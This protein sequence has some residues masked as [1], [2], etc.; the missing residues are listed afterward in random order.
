MSANN[1]S[2]SERKQPPNA[3]S[4]ISEGGPLERERS[5]MDQ[6]LSVLRSREA[7]PSKTFPLPSSD[8]PSPESDVGERALPSNF[9]KKLLEEYRQRQQGG[10]APPAPGAPGDLLPEA[11]LPPPANNWIPIG[12]AVVRQGQASN[13]PAVSGRI[14]GLAIAPGG[15][16]IYAASA[17]GGVWRSDDGGLTWQ[18]TMEAWDLNPTTPSSDTLACGAIAINPTNPNRIFVGTGE[19]ASGAY[20][21]V[22]PIRSDN[23]GVSWVTEPTAPGSSTLEGS[24]FYRLAMDPGDPDRL[25][26]ATRQGLY[27][28]EPDG[29]GAFHWA[30]KSL[31]G[32]PYLWVTGVAAARSGSTTTFYAAS[33]GGSVYSSND[34]HTWSQ[35]GTGFPT[36]N[37]GRIGLAVQPNNPTVVYALICYWKSGD[38]NTGSMLGVWRLDTNDNI[39]RQVGGYPTDLF[40]TPG[41]YQG[42]YDLAIAV[43]P[44]N[45]N[46][47]YLGGST[48]SAGG[49]W[50]GSLYRCIVSSSGSG[51][52]LTY[53][54]ANTFIG[55]TVHADIHALEFT[56]G[57]SDQLWV[58]CD[59]GVF[60][61]DSATGSASFEARNVGLAC[62]TMNH[63][64]QHPTEDAVVFCGTQ[65]NGTT[66]FTGEEVWLHSAPGD[67]GFVV[68]NWNDPYRMLRTYVRGSIYRATDGGQSY[69][70]WSSV[71][72][73]ATHR[74]NALFYAPLVGTPH[75]TA[76]PAEA[77]I[78]AFGGQRPWLSTNFG[79]S[80]QSIPNNNSSDDLVGPI[81]SLAFA[82]AA[83]LY[84]GTNDSLLDWTPVNSAVYRFDKSGATWTRTRI[85]TVGGANVLPLDGPI[86]DIAIDLADPSGDSIYITFGGTGDYRHVWHFNGTQWQQRSGPAAGSAD[87]LLDVQYNAIVIDPSHTNH[88]YA[89]ADIGVWRSTDGGA[90]WS[91]FSNGLPDAAVLDLKLHN[92]RRLLRASTHGRGV[93]ERT[94]DTTMALGV[95]LYVRDTQLD[96]GRHPTTNGLD[97]PTQPGETVRHYQG[98]DIKVDVPSAMGTYQTPT[99]QINCYQF[100]DTIVDGSGG[101]ATVDPS[102]GTAINRMYVQVHN[103]GVT[104][105]SGVQVMVLLANAS[106]G[107]PNLPAGYDTDVRA[108]T[109]I[110][111]TN[112][113]TVGIQTLNDLQVGLPQIASFNL[114]SSMLPP[115]ASLAGNTH[116]CLLALLHCPGND[117]FTNTQTHVDTLSP[118]ERKAAHKNLHV[119]Q[120]TG[121]LPPAAPEWLAI[122]LH[123]I[124]EREV[125]SDLVLNLV[126]YQGRVRLMVPE[127][128][129]LTKSLD[130]SLVGLR[131]EDAIDFDEWAEKKL[132]QLDYYLEKRL[133]NA[134][135]C[136]QMIEAIN[137]V[138]G[139]PMLLAETTKEPAILRH[140]M[141]HP[142]EFHTIFVAINRPQEARIGD[143]YEF[144]IYQR[145]VERETMWGGSTYQV[146]IVP[147]PDVEEKLYL[148]I[149]G[150]R[151]WFRGYEVV[152][153]RVFD[154]DGAILGSGEGAEVGLFIH[155]N[156]G[157]EGK[158]RPMRYHRG[159]RAFWLRV[160]LLPHLRVGVVK[161][162]AVA[163]AQDREARKTETIRF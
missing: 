91:T 153:V 159:W 108:G 65:D 13:R 26:G 46:R 120:F 39:W 87:S 84:A 1:Q 144:T 47:V 139:Q 146:Q 40:G 152:F 14:A 34:G 22:G 60:Y 162:T 147:E 96:L 136:K 58:G 138:R 113:Q 36:V 83:R 28:R 158:L 38:A 157:I 141:M 68:I 74:N 52:S 75:N 54:M 123:G 4:E 23:G 66:R 151:W 94:L 70:S 121:T 44:N 104:P 88:L 63:L 69:S 12:P 114:P 20:F 130:Q 35:L 117:I 119:V 78:V 49:Q 5:F 30:E 134:L 101:V 143:N 89:G 124:P 122:R 99:N 33:W 86:T 145:D 21:G 82:S 76:A 72:L 154:E 163:R 17:N 97:D 6:R 155:T 77:D 9:R 112:W 100:V 2:S 18:S 79:T 10:A 110:N 19:G 161:V 15:I 7:P 133:F 116:H 31:P 50:S 98:P 51:T 150:K 32:A 37:V 118:Q 81:L 85:D 90:T 140:V 25:V 105:A 92:G 148:K 43:D 27:R 131:L 64:A 106:A 160:N 3:R 129:R 73:P 29:S 42:T 142:D 103:R 80:W 53:S 41:Y 132:E 56:P 115:P 107:L 93:Y 59:G 45:V 62:L 67:G 111:T 61:T 128:L 48:K 109:A 11:P 71:S 156:R 102:V 55:A 137:K 95:E 16:Q 8:Q 126:D 127:D 57:D 135:W 125:L 24:A 149:W